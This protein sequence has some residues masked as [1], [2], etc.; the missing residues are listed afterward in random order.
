ML[1]V[2]SS[3]GCPFAHRTRAVLTHLEVPFRLHEID[4]TNRDR[5]FLKLTPT[6]KV[7][8]LIDGD[9]ILYESQ[10][11]N[12]YLAE[13]YGWRQAFASDTRSRAR[14]L[15]A[16]KQWDGVVLPAFYD[17][18]RDPTA[19]E[20]EQRVGVEAEL[21]QLAATVEATG[22]RVDRLL[23]FHVA[24]HWA[25][26]IWL[27]DFTL[28]VDLVEQRPA[29]AR[30]LDRAAAQPAVRKTLPDREQTIQRYRE[31]YVGRLA[32]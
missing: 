23:G 24:T 7:P 13:A 11:I 25:R 15:L 9:F 30:W 19:L 29:L 31:V 5:E 12:T 28:I 32:A 18:L 16:M 14:E 22:P 20:G 3:E 1:E 27:R 26:M 6:G 10:I 2:Y 8:L 17:S 21:D 4:T